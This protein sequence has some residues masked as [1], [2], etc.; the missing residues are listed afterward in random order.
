M[1]G[2][3]QTT[4]PYTDTK[5][6]GAAGFYTAI[7]ATFRFIEQ[8]LGREGLLRYWQELGSRYYAPV[9]RKWH[10]GGLL[11]VAN[12]WR[13]FFAAEPGGEVEVTAD[14][15]RVTIEVKTCP[16]IHHLRE[17]GRAIFPA[18]CQHCYF[19]SDAMAEP[20]GFMVR[21]EGGNGSCTQRFAARDTSA[22]GQRLEDI[23]SCEAES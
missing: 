16:M 18:F 3:S 15:Q 6:V 11:A 22:P 13:D 8:K 23:H 17:Q 5:P 19:V 21:V 1:S 2:Q 20:A 9:S 10:E 7:N 14:Q 4:L 12:Y